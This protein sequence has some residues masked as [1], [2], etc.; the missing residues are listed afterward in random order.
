IGWHIRTGEWIL[1]TRSVP[2]VDSFSSLMSGKPWYAWEWL[3]EAGIGA[4]HRGLGLNGVVAFSA[5]VI[6][7]T[8][9]LVFRMMRKRGTSLPIAVAVLL[10][11]VSASSIHFLARPHVV[12]WL[13]TVI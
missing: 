11:A 12:S 6:A 8:F 1:R 13:L 7:F 3:Y 4:I 5:L 10:L 2:R 9:A